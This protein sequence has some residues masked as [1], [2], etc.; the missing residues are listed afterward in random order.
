[1]DKTYVELDDDLKS[2]STLTVAHAKIRLTPGYK[3]N[4]KAFI[5]WTRDKISI[6]I[7]PITVILQVAN[8]S[9]FIKRYKHHSAY[10]KKNNI[11]TLELYGKNKLDRMVS[12][13]HQL[14]TRYS[15]KE[16]NSPELHLQSS[17]RD[18]T[19]YGLW[20]LYS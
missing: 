10:V 9:D 12:Y 14:P 5:Q 7:D 17:K 19:N 1:M 6:G 4:I 16:R 15:G 3:K 8:A 11:E 13:L 2:Y 18:R 20:R